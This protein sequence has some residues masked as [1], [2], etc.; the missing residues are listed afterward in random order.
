MLVV[1]QADVVGD[2]AGGVDIVRDDQHRGIDLCVEVDDELVEVRR[3]NRV[4]ARVWLVKENDFGVEHQGAGETGALAHTAGDFAGQLVFGADQAD[5]F[6]LVHDDFA[7]LGLGLLGVLAERESHIVV[8][9]HRAEHSAVLE[10]D[11][12]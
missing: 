6:H 9:V 3:T 4:E 10:K 7:D 2:R 12:E 8:E 5:K 11:A 1:Q